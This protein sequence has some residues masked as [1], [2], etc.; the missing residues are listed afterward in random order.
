M[1]S[2]CLKKSLAF[3]LTAMMVLSVVPVYGL[4]A[5]NTD[6]S[7]AQPVQPEVLKEQIVLSAAEPRALTDSKIEVTAKKNS[8]S[9]DFTCDPSGTKIAVAAKANFLSTVKGTVTIK[10]KSSKAVVLSFR[11][12]ATK[13]K[14]SGAVS[15]TSGAYHNVV[16]AG[17]SISINFESGESAVIL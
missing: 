16:N 13:D 15:G 6:D 14:V 8:G 17:A 4:A 5:E 1:F 9:G 7:S 12:Y 10:N 11:Y 3:L 2:K